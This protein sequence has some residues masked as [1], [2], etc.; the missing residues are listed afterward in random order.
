MESSLPTQ[1]SKFREAFIKLGYLPRALALAWKAA[2]RWTIAQVGLLFVQGL[3]PASLI[4]LTKLLIDSLT[5]AIKEGATPANIRAVVWNATLMGAITLLL[6]VL[7]GIEQIIR[8][9]LVEKL[10]DHI[11]ALIHQKSITVDLAFYER[12]DYFDHLHRA[13]DEAT[14]RPVELMANVA[15]LLR[16]GVTLAAMGAVLL[17]F[18][19]WL[20]LVLLLSTLPALYVVLRFTLKSHDWRRRN[21]PEQRKAWYYDWLLTS[22]DTAAELRLFGLGGYFKRKFEQIRKRLRHERLRLAVS[23]HVAELVAGSAAL[24]VTAG[25]LAWMLWRV[26]NGFGTLGDLVLFYQAFNQG[27]GLMRSLL[28]N[29]GQLYAT[30][31]FLGDLFEYLSLEPKVVDP[32]EPVEALPVLREG[33]TFDHVTFRYQEDGRFALRDFNLT[34]PAN[35]IVAIVGSN[36]AGK[37]TLLKLLCRFYDP[38]GGQIRFDGVD[39]RQ[40]ALA[41][42]RRM[43][44]VLF[45]TTVNYSA[46][47]KENIAVA[48]LDRKASLAEVASA[49]RASGAD[50][51]VAHLPEGYESL[52]GNWFPGGTE[53]SVGEWQRIALA[54]AFLRKAPLILLDEPTSAMDPWAETDWLARLLESAKGHT[55]VLITH[56]FTTARCADVIHVMEEGRIIESGSHEEL[57]ALGG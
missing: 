51:T 43:V 10:Q 8:T 5:L 34:I 17:R 2:R 29:V 24:V 20:P 31:L 37:S 38:E 23:Q 4:Y 7:G 22:K 18:G 12:P 55:V 26:L 1:V 49:A 39:L 42:L 36:G 56:R 45:Q 33:I 21:T 35:R 25:A 11:F 14:Y 44:T 48:D 53:L 15:S 28:Q 32:S 19:Y 40:Y 50:V 57:V 54:R 27:Q 9:A 41:E 6:Q 46:T 16:N 47:V 52:L 3:L 13:R 30:S